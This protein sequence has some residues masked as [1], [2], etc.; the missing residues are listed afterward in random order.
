MDNSTAQLFQ[1]NLRGLSFSFQLDSWTE[2]PKYEV[3]LFLSLIFIA[4]CLGDRGQKTVP[5]E[6]F[7]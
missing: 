7:G 4:Q 6:E 2:A 3:S 1:L 5:L